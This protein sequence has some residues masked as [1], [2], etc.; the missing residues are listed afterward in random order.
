MRNLASDTQN[1]SQAMQALQFRPLPLLEDFTNDV[2][3][4]S[5]KRHRRKRVAMSEA[6]AS[7]LQRRALSETESKRRTK[8]CCIR[9]PNENL[10]LSR[11]LHLLSQANAQHPQACCSIFLKISH[12]IDNEDGSLW[13]VFV[14]KEA[15][16]IGHWER[17]SSITEGNCVRL[18]PVVDLSR[19]LVTSFHGVV[20]NF[21]YVSIA[22][23]E[24]NC[25]EEDKI[26]QVC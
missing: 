9:Y 1:S 4:T 25:I 19:K 14:V 15:I 18:N 3:S 10:M 6:D 23:L 13:V 20:Q 12:F 26:V 24:S 11:V 7:L 5:Q 16:H 22:A 2:E 8:T 17:I 21:P